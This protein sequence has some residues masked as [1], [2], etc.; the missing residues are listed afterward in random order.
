VIVMAIQYTAAQ[1]A[2]RLTAMAHRMAEERK[3]S[4]RE[5]AVDVRDT[6]RSAIGTY[7]FGWPRLSTATLA[8]KG[9]DTPLLVTGELR[10]S[11]KYT[12]NPNGTEAIVY[13]DD[14]KAAHHELGTRKMPPR[15]FLV[16]A[17][18]TREKAVVATFDAGL[19]KAIED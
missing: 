14:P 16:P 12:I 8:K 2:A 1:F 17:A 13:S 11:I 5:I 7:R 3:V 18:Q 4:M 6:A 9:A 19:K 10:R 15:P